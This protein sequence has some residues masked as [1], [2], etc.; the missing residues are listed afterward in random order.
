MWDFIC[1]KTSLRGNSDIEDQFQ[2]Y[3]FQYMRDY[4]ASPLSRRKS[5]KQAIF[6]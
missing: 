2:G 5:N 4:F 3:Y 6:E 1:K